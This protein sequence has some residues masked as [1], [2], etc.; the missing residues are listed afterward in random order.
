MST[1][2]WTI[3]A[4]ATALFAAACAAPP[5]AVRRSALAPLGNGP[6]RSGRPLDAGEVRIGGHFTRTTNGPQS[7]T[8]DGLLF[9]D[10][11]PREES[12]GV[13]IPRNVGG[14]FAYVGVA[15]YLEVGASFN[16]ASMDSAEANYPDHVLPFDTDPMVEFGLGVRGN[17]PI[18]DYFTLSILTQLTAFN[19][20]QATFLCEN[21][22]AMERNEF[23]PDRPETGW[24]TTE[25]EFNLQEIDN[26]A[27]VRGSLMVEPVFRINEYF[28]V[29]P[30]FGVSQSVKNIGFDPERRR[31]QDDTLSHYA[32]G[33]VGIGAEARYGYG[34]FGLN[35]DYLIST[36]DDIGNMPAVTANFGLRIPGRR[37]RNGGMLPEEALNFDAPPAAP[38]DV[39]P[40]PAPETLEERRE[41]LQREL[42]ALDTAIEDT[43]PPAR[44]P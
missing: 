33:I 27:A 12:P 23:S 5:V 10:E 6:V 21:I 39:T 9:E 18:G 16:F 22:T 34:F 4:V 37:E 2:R 42:D 41:R 14:A 19:V 25:D 44:K 31:A 28:A 36:A 15:E 13:F 35:F 32:V 7:D 30:H 1:T 38:S 29:Y 24:C 40:A 8:F 26:H 20:Q 17:I 11:V 3:V 43:E